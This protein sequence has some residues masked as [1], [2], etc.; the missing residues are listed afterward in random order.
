MLTPAKGWALINS[1]RLVKLK[2][3]WVLSLGAAK[4][5]LAFPPCGAIGWD[6]EDV[7]NA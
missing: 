3:L 7:E 6:V 4:P 1:T 2:P 5:D